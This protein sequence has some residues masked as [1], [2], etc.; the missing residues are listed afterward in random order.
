M[1]SKIANEINKLRGERAATQQTYMETLA[2]LADEVQAINVTIINLESDI[3]K[4]LSRDI[5]RVQGEALEAKTESLAT[6]GGRLNGEID[7][8]GHDITGISDFEAEDD[9]VGIGF[10]NAA[11]ALTLGI[12]SS[13]NL[14]PQGTVDGR[15]LDTDG[16]K[17]DGCDTGSKDDQTNAEIKAAVEAATDSNTFTDADHTKLNAIESSATADQSN[18]EIKTAI[19]AA[20][21][22]INLLS[23]YAFTTTNGMYRSNQ[24]DDTGSFSFNYVGFAGGLTRFR[25]I[26]I[27]DGKQNRIM[28][29]DGSS[30][31]VTFDGD[32]ILTGTV[33]GRDL[34]V[35]GIKLDAIEASATADQSNAEI[36]AAVEAATDSNTFTDADHT[37]LNTLDL[38]SG[39][40]IQTNSTSPTSWT[41]LN[42]SS[43]TSASRCL[44]TLSIRD[45]GGTGKQVAF[46]TNGS[47]YDIPLG[48]TGGI[49]TGIITS[50]GQTIYIMVITDTSGIV[51]WIANNNTLCT[52]KVESYTKLT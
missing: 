12:D 44:V 33:D 4:S 9:T 26:N 52:V 37:K 38:Y 1:P 7:M 29:I 27:Y 15:D 36:K 8:D 41:D 3:K 32:I 10:Y 14:T 40:D 21:T 5:K 49:T 50:S 20:T 48:G 42:L 6:S 13:G 11:S 45:T 19:E 22:S 16:T 24:D 18:A 35:D 51:E 34:S 23:Q 43:I 25:D 2:T 31:D 30:K 47:G 46:R 28:F 39:N 17:L